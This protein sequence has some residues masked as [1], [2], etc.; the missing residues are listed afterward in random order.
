MYR[1]GLLGAAVKLN[2]CEGTGCMFVGR[3]FSCVP[4]R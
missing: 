2:C 1:G 4:L 3:S